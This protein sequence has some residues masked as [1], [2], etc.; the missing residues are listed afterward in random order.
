[1]YV[2]IN[3]KRAMFCNPLFKAERYSYPV[4][5]PRALDYCLRAVYWKPQMR[6][7]IKRICV[8]NEPKY[9]C[10]IARCKTAKFPSG[11]GA[12]LR[13]EN[14]LKDVRYGVEFDIELTGINPTGNNT[15]EKH[16]AILRQRLKKGQYYKVPYLG[17]KE[18]AC[19]ISLADGFPETMLSG[20]TIH[21]GYM[22]HHVDIDDEGNPKSTWYCPVMV[23]GVID[24]TTKRKPDRWEEG[25]FV[26]NLVNLYEMHGEALGMPPEGF[27]EARVTYEAIVSKEGKLK[28]IKPLKTTDK[29]KPYPTLMKVPKAAIKTFNVAANFLWGNADYL[30][31]SDEKRNAFVQK[32]SEVV[33]EHPP[34]AMEPILRMY[35]NFDAR[36]AERLLKDAGVEAEN[37]VFRVE[38]AKEFV[39]EDSGVREKWLQYVSKGRS[40]KKEFCVI[41]GRNAPMALKHP[42][43]RGVYGAGS[44]ARLLSLDAATSSLSSYNYKGNLNAP[45]SEEASEK[46]HLALNHLLRTGNNKFD[47]DNG[48]TVFWTRNSKV[49]ADNLAAVTGN[50]EVT[51]VSEVPEGEI[52]YLMELRGNGTGR[53]YVRQY[54]RLVY[55]RNSRERLETFLIRAGCKTIRF[56]LLGQWEGESA[57][58]EK[59]ERGYLLGRLFAVMEQASIDALREP[60]NC[61]SSFYAQNFGKAAARPAA[62]FARLH[63]KAMIYLQKTDYGLGRTYTEVVRKLDKLIMPYPETQNAREKALFLSGYECEKA[64]LIKARNERL[65]KF[66]G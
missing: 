19:E 4:P 2:E 59:D 17:T 27:E 16:E 60:F 45:M 53:V 52:F 8:V 29:N 15:V 28:A 61:T 1:M 13:S 31:R 40:D 12:M 18:C 24:A 3:A 65:K 36:S 11:D 20:K 64:A 32:L 37:I 56:D 62:A 21:L 23:N 25:C 51:F 5:T 42:T 55:G 10:D 34:Q 44:L 46:F 49:L 26:K 38:E 47:S 66:N 63:G 50:E 43:V 54:E 58:S 14:Y 7:V 57:K 39:L 48:T 6:Y 35:D 9:G 30:F 33:G 41:S 22:L